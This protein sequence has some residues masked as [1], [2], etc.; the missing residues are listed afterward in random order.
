MS[1]VSPGPANGT[2]VVELDGTIT[3]THNGSPTTSDSST[4]RITDPDGLSDTATVTIRHVRLG[5]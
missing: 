3:D 4:Y 5:G 2:A 1:I